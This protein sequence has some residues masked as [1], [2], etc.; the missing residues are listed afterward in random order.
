MNSPLE[1]A[2]KQ[3]EYERRYKLLGPTRVPLNAF[4]E[5]S[6]PYPGRNGEVVFKKALTLKREWATTDYQKMLEGRSNF[7]REDYQVVVIPPRNPNNKNKD[8]TED[9][10]N[11]L[12]EERLGK[13]PVATLERQD[14]KG[15]TG[16]QGRSILGKKK[17]KTVYIVASIVDDHDLADVQHVA[18]KYRQYGEDVEINLVSPFIKS[19]RD[20]KT[21][22]LVG[23]N[24]IKKHTGK[25]PSIAVTMKALSQFV[26]NIYTYETH[27]SAT[28]SFAAVY[29]MRLVPISLQ[30]ELVGK[31][32][33][34]NKSFDPN[35][36]R[37]VRP[38]VGRTMVAR[39][40]CER[41]KIKGVSL[42]KFR[43][44]DT[45]ESESSL[46]TEEENRVI[47]GKNALLYD[48]EA[49]TFGT[50]RDITINHL[51]KANVKS[52]NILLGHGRLQKGWDKNLEIMIG[53]CKE[54]NIPLKIYIT[55]SR[56]PIEISDLNSFL[57]KHPGIIDI[58]SVAQKTRSVIMATSD[59]VNFFNNNSH[60]E[61]DWERSILQKI[62]GYDFR[63]KNGNSHS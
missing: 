39:R 23:K 59:K 42:S 58:V 38:D 8:F 63:T 35:E 36:W 1:T 41:L 51:L 7:E 62:E 40:I 24:K 34:D 48:D 57:E 26:N 28:Q 52:I 18:Y 49:A 9:F 10:I 11:S 25:I 27:S 6:L 46:L 55:N 20:D 56:L 13:Y 30:N 15:D 31:F 12:N 60:N 22:E 19:E 45:I 3:L 53:A 2:K 47:N 4:V 33:D 5:D 21:V 14:Y 29:G 16:D 43:K 61:I 50:V 44:G 37:D 17:V 32:L 54:K